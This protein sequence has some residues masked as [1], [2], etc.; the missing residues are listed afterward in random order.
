MAVPRVVSK[1]TGTHFPAR[2]SLCDKISCA[3]PLL[4]PCLDRL[5]SGKIA[6]RISVQLRVIAET[7]SF[8]S[9]VTA[10]CSNLVMECDALAAFCERNL[11]GEQDSPLEFDLPVPFELRPAFSYHRSL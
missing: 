6:D 11:S 5:A 2:C 3:L 9:Q 4:R 8:Q 10:D 1:A 7:A